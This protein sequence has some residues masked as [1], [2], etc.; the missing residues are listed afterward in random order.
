MP[1]EYRIVYHIEQRDP[2]SPLWYK[3]LYTSL[4]LVVA[5][6]A[7]ATSYGAVYEY[8]RC[9]S[10]DTS[11]LRANHYLGWVGVVVGVVGALGGLAALVLWR[12]MWLT[13]VTK[14]APVLRYGED[15]EDIEPGFLAASGARSFLSTQSA[16]DATKRE[17]DRALVDLNQ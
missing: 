2:R 9:T 7:V 8:D 14:T 12:S 16:T 10:G 6:F 3:L 13:R 4:C 11:Y 5:L 15:V 17:V 1:A